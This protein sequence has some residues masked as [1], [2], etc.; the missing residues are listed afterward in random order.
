MGGRGK[1]A[2]ENLPARQ[3]KTRRPKTFLTFRAASS[4]RSRARE[5][6]NDA[7]SSFF[8]SPLV[9]ASSTT[10]RCR[11]A[12]SSPVTTSGT[13][14]VAASIDGADAETASEGARAAG[15]LAS[16]SDDVELANEDEAGGRWGAGGACDDG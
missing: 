11:R 13:G 15:G 4:D 6:P 5:S 2:G 16:A 14:L 7:T 10:C 8:S 9:R 3:Q 1:K 12:D